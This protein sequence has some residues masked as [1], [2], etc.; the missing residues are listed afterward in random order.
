[1]VRILFWK[2]AHE[3]IVTD[4]FRQKR[5]LT[6]LGTC[7]ICDT[8][9]EPVLHMVRDC[10]GAM[11]IW[12][13]LARNN[14]PLDFF[15]ADLHSWLI[16]NLNCS[17]L[18]HGL[19][20]KIIFGAASS[21]IWQSRNNKV[22][23]SKVDTVKDLCCKVM[24]QARSFHQSAL[25]CMQTVPLLNQVGHN[26]IRW[27]APSLGAWKLNC[28][29]VVCGF[30]TISSAGGVLKDHHG[31]FIFGF[32][33]A[34]K[35]YTVM[36][37]KLHAI[38]VGLNLVRLKGFRN[39]EIEFDSL[40]AVRFIKEWCSSRHLLFNLIND[41]QDKFRLEGVSCVN[42]V[43]REVNQLADSFAMFGLSLNNYSRFFSC[44]PSFASL[45]VRADSWGISFLRGF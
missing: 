3:A 33:L 8:E 18:V 32:A 1:M 40:Y 20:W 16:N 30:G 45:A 4:L 21:S 44:I 27:A 31:N 14:L 34:L 29:G 25:D 11:Q 24:F 10:R 12:T 15:T 19:D 38:S 36:E 35:S 43:L 6:T 42:H 28:D 37:V 41:I 9:E 39:V 7:P 23:N 22:F 26:N 5:G 13:H 17:T 2:M